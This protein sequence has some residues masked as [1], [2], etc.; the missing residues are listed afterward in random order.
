MGDP[1]D[2]TGLKMLTTFF[3]G[4]ILTGA[5]A[6]IAYPHDLPTKADIEKLQQQTGG[7]LE[8]MQKQNNAE[9][10][11]ITSLRIELAKIAF[12]LHIE[13]SP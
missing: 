6:F 4:I 11:E 3:A 5:A 2:S 9:E 13:D 10:N 12:K 8:E 7:Q 1:S